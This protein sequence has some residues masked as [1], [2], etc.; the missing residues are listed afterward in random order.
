MGS[1][2]RVRIWRAAEKIHNVDWFVSGRATK[3][4]MNPVGTKPD[5]VGAA[6]AEVV[7]AVRAVN[8]ADAPDSEIICP[9]GMVDVVNVLLRKVPRLDMGVT[10]QECKEGTLVDLVREH[11]ETKTNVRCEGRERGIFTGRRREEGQ[12][13]YLLC[14]LLAQCAL[15][16]IQ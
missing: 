1:G 6:Y 16:T 11:T 13:S 10:V 2:S 14:F 8:P 3:Q 4:D 15:G 5:W 12:N 9:M 7:T